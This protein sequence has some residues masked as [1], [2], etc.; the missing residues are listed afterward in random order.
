MRKYITLLALSLVAAIF[1]GCA[2]TGSDKTRT[3]HEEKTPATGAQ[4]GWTLNPTD[5]NK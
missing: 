2:S 5:D 1:V 4:P 3:A